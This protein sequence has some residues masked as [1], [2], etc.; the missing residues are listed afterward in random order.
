MKLSW[1]A[2]GKTQ[3]AKNDYCVI[4]ATANERS[5]AINGQ[6]MALGAP[7]VLRGDTMYL[8]KLDFDN[9]VF[10]LLS[11]GQI[12]GVPSLRRI[13]IDPGHGGT[14]I[15]TSNTDLKANEKTNTLD[16]ALRLAAVLRQRGYDVV[17]TRTTDVFVELTDRTAIANRAKGDLYISIH[18]NNAPQ[19]S[20]SGV[21]TWILPP[22]GQPPTGER[23]EE[24]DKK[25]LPGDRYDLWN[26]IVGFSVERSA[27]RELGA[28]NRG[29]KRKHLVVL[30]EL[31]MPGLLIECGFLSN[32]E[33]GRK[34][35]SGDYRQKIAV[36]LANGIDLYKAT[37]EHLRP[38][39][40]I[41]TPVPLPP[42]PPTAAPHRPESINE[43]IP[44]Q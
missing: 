12:A 3:Q 41:S 7:I 22:P 30:K 42:P 43:I 8:S 34:I 24:A 38:G 20:V 26:T 21:E 10:P 29:L 5:L 25:V 1:V 28:E 35:I 6:P 36:A 11:P 15:G 27:A 40:A 19:K 2:P 31:N 37:L 23:M 16:T 17:L 14:D 33:E 18:F 9:N 39:A 32:P 44:P 4:E 13:V